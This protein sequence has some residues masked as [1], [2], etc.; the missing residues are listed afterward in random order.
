LK[1]TD[2][3]SVTNTIEMLEIIHKKKFKIK[4]K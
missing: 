2:N 1:L 3:F 4:K